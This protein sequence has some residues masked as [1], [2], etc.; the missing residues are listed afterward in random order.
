[1]GCTAWH[2]FHQSTPSQTAPSQFVVG[3]QPALFPAPFPTAPRPK[4]REIFKASRSFHA[5]AASVA[6]SMGCQASRVASEAQPDGGAQAAASKRLGETASDEESGR[7]ASMATSV[8]AGVEVSVQMAAAME[9]GGIAGVLKLM[10]AN[11]SDAEFQWWGA[12]AIAGLCAGNGACC[13]E[14]TE[15]KEGGRKEVSPVG[16]LAPLHRPLVRCSH[17]QKPTLLL[18]TDTQKKGE[19]GG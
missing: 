12:D 16:R 9:E 15:G 3:K 6:A 14:V 4:S 5:F 1:M 18:P 17:L 2:Q 11:P 10:K 19:R 13:G 8:G 7:R